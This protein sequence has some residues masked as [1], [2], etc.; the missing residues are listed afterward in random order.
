MVRVALGGSKSALVIAAFAFVVACERESPVEPT[1]PSLC[2]YL[3]TPTEFAPCMAEPDLLAV[4]VLAGPGCPW[5]AVSTDPWLSPQGPAAGTGSGTLVVAVADNWD[6]PR[7]GHITVRGSLPEHRIDVRVSQAG[8]VYGVDPATVDVA[9]PGGTYSFR[10]VQ[11]SL[12]A[13]CGGPR[14]DACLWSATTEAWWITVMTP[15]PRVGDDEVTLKMTGNPTGPM[16]EGLVM[17]R[18]QVVRVVQRAR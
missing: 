13:S 2:S 9:W 17:V 1:P 4:T 7:A 6:A 16:R 5:T 12:P 11:Q 8:C 3:A 10:V 18:D 14:Q 15:M